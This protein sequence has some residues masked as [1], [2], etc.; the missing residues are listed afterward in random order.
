VQIKL[1]LSKLYYTI[2]E[3]A[4]MFDVN[5]SL[6]R[7]WEKEFKTLSPAK[8][9]NGSRK[10]T[11]KDI[12]DFNHIYELVKEQGFTIDGARKA[13]TDKRLHPS[14]HSDDHQ[15]DSL[16]KKLLSLQKKLLHLQ[17]EMP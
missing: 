7:Y 6:I 17:K 4:E 15:M 12:E 1:P 14:E 3:V 10:Y 8:N 9:R 11:E 16:L 13:I 2:S 5:A